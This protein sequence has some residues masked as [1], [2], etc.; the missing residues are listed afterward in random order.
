MFRTFP[1]ILR[2]YVLTRLATRE[3]TPIYQPITNNYAS[4]HFWL[5]EKL[6]IHQNTSNHFQQHCLQN[7]LLTALIVENRPIL[8]GTYFLI[9]RKR[10][11][12]NVK[13]F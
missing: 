7:L 6:L 9:L 1:N 8:V 2:S 12:P 11:S 10:P 4:F 5:K 13:S 3:A